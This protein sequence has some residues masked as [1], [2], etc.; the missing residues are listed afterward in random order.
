VLMGTGGAPEGVIAAAA[1]RCQGGDI[2]G[3]LRPRN[4]GEADRARAMG[5][6]DV[7]AKLTL[8]ELASGD[9]LFA[10]TGVTEGD[11]L[12]GVRFRAEGALTHSVVMRSHSMTTRWIE[13]Q[14]NFRFKPR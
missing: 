5:I 2:Q 9:V 7:N 14:H 11:F 1:L 10:G 8:E 4:Q 13:A 6:K 3:R 12:K